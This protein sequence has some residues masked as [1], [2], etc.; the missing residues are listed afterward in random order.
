MDK[1]KPAKHSG[2]KTQPSK[3]CP[4]DVQPKAELDGKNDSGPDPEVHGKT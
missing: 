2:K 1:Q 4:D 3:P